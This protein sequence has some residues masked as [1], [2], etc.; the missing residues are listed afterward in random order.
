MDAFLD[1]LWL[2][3]VDGAWLVKDL[4]DAVFR[5]VEALGPAAAIFA[6]A[7]VTVVLARLLSKTCKTRRYRQLREEFQHWYE[8]R[9]Q[10]L[11][12]KD[13]D[14]EKAR[15]LARNID[16]GKLNKLYYDYFFEG[17][18]LSLATRYLPFFLFFAYVNESYRPDALLARFGRDYLLQFNIPDG[19]SLQI[20]SLLWFVIAV[21]LINILWWAI[22]KALSK[23]DSQT[24]ANSAVMPASS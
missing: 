15:A 13:A 10:A 9:R 11:Q 17:F 12:L 7:L 24:D 21:L 5:P 14:R 1:T 3:I 20:G 4:L 16:Q 19:N 18:M 2:K 6:V 23:P 8:V 22:R